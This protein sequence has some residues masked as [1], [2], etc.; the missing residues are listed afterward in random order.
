MGKIFST[1]FGGK[2]SKSKQQSQSTQTSYNQA[3]P[4]IDTA[5]SPVLGEAQSGANAFD[6]MLNGDTT[7]FDKYKDATGYDLAESDGLRKIIGSSAGQGIFRSGAT[8][9]ALESFGTNLQQQFAGN[10]LSNLLQKANLGFQAGNTM[11]GAG[12][13]MSGQSTS[14]GTSSSYDKPGLLSFGKLAQG[15]AGGMGG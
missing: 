14:K 7:G 4:Q 10:Y 15:I 8:G 2:G 6:A 1:I 13:Y 11:T 3:Y 5:M 12:G 9:K